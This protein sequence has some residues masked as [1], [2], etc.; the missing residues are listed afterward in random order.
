ME[1]LKK[2]L[3]EVSSSKNKSLGLGDHLSLEELINEATILE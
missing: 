3:A 2:H 1:F